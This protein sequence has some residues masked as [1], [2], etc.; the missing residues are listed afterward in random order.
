MCAC[1]VVGLSSCTYLLFRVFRV[2]REIECSLSSG[3]TH[4]HI[5]VSH[6][7]HV[8]RSLLLDTSSY[9]IARICTMF[10]HRSTISVTCLFLFLHIFR[11]LFSVL[12]RKFECIVVHDD[13]MEERSAQIETVPGTMSERTALVV[14]ARKCFRIE[15]AANVRPGDRLRTRFR[16]NESKRENMRQNYYFM[17]CHNNHNRKVIYKPYSALVRHRCAASTAGDAAVA[18]CAKRYKL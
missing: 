11:V 7:V 16:E 14:R 13:G 2:F 6:N 5:I 12:C 9:L 17:N 15:H 3:N 18:V 4:V 8:C 10:M 1:F